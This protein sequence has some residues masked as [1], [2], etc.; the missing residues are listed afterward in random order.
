MQ[1]LH[2]EVAVFYGA[3]NTRKYFSYEL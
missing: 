3:V 2:F 1:L